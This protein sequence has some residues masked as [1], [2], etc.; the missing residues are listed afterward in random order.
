M[1]LPTYEQAVG[2]TWPPA[3]PSY[4]SILGESGSTD[5]C[6]IASASETHVLIE[7]CSSYIN[8]Y[9]YL[10]IYLFNYMGVEMKSSINKV[11][12]LNFISLF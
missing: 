3:P 9:I 12:Q 2:T 1:A 11:I 6:S 8:I 7:R 10:F 5:C 4:E